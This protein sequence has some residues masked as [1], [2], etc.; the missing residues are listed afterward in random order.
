MLRLIF[1]F[2]LECLYYYEIYQ[3]DENLY[4]YGNNFDNY[5]IDF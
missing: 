5:I 1:F 4:I 2:Y 3:F